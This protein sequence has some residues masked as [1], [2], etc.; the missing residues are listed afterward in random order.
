MDKETNRLY[1]REVFFLSG[2]QCNPVGSLYVHSCYISETKTVTFKYRVGPKDR[3][4]FRS[5]P[6]GFPANLFAPHC[7]Y[8][9]TTT[10][11]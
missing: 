7:T 6:M 5:L 4:F 11:L 1:S 10:V 9:M 2:I 8:R 3:P